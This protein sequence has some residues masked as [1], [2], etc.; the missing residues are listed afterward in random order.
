FDFADGS[1]RQV[2]SKAEG[3]RELHIRKT[4]SD[5]TSGNIDVDDGPVVDPCQDALVRNLHTKLV[6]AAVFEG[7]I[8]ARFVAGRGP[9]IGGGEP[10]DVAAPAARHPGAE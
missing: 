3:S 8:F 6:P 1:L 7:E 10:D 2:R 4:Q 9:P 5:F